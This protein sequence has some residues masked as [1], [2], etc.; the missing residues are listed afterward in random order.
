[1]SGMQ[2]NLR[3]LQQPD[4]GFRLSGKA[5]LVQP[6]LCASV[7]THNSLPERIHERQFV[8]ICREQHD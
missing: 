7:C 3:G 8:C 6:Y 2:H 5:W 4:L 1:M